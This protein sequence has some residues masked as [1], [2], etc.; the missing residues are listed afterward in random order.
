LIRAAAMTARIAIM[1]A[2]PEN[3]AHHWQIEER[4]RPLDVVDW[5]R[6]SFADFSVGGNQ[7]EVSTAVPATPR[8]S[9]FRLVTSGGPSS[10]VSVE[11]TGKVKWFNTR[12]AMASLLGIGAQ[13]TY[14]STSPL[15][16]DP[17]SRA[18]AKGIA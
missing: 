14:S 6:F 4:R 15:L 8:R 17:G 5:C 3:S 2:S 9:G 10:D 18:S 12:K 13:R 7:A 1:R 11:S 16:N